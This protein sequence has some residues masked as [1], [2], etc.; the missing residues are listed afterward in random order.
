MDEVWQGT[1]NGRCVRVGQG[2]HTSGDGD[3]LLLAAGQA[4]AALAHV[5]RKLVGE[6][7]DKVVG[8]GLPRRVG[9]F[10]L[11]RV[12]PRVRNVAGDR[13]GKQE[14]VLR[15]Q[16]DLLAKPRRVQRAHIAA[17]DRDRALQPS[18]GKHHV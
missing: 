1:N 11:G 12:R 14:R 16:A 10:G 18:S 8:V 3:A 13:A 5:G 4:Q 15:D 6:G 17:V 7:H 9:N 2:G